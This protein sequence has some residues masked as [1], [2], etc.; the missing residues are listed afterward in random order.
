MLFCVNSVFL[1][2]TA[3]KLTELILF[4]FLIRLTELILIAEKMNYLN[5][6]DRRVT[7]QEI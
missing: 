5:M 6:K 7:L 2:H 4:F 3:I 1:D